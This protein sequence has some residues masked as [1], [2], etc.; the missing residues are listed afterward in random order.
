MAACLAMLALT[1][2]GA[3]GLGGGSSDDSGAP[4]STMGTFFHNM[5]QG[6]PDLPPAPAGPAPQTRFPGGVTP[7]EEVECPILEVAANGAALREPPGQLEGGSQALHYQISIQHVARE[8]KDAGAEIA[9]K[10][11]VEGSVI[12]GPSGAP[13]TYS[14]PLLFEAKIDDKVVASRRE[15]L[16]VAVPA[17]RG[18][19]FFDAVVTDFLVPKNDDLDLYVGLSRGGGEPLRTPRH[20]RRHARR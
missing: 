4:R 10:L 5:V 16:S 12:L 11:G 9:M 2:C 8:C 1:G 14:V 7:K 6:G 3:L 13:G 18:R 19:A 15:T 20:H 17:D